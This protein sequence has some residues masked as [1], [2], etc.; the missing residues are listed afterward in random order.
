MHDGNLHDIAKIAIFALDNN[1][2]FT[3]N[4]LR[5]FPHCPV[6]GFT[7]K[8]ESLLRTIIQVE[9]ELVNNFGKDFVLGQKRRTFINQTTN[10]DHFICG[11]GHSIIDIDWN[12][13]VYPCHLL[14]K[15]CF[16][17]GNLIEDEIEAIVFRMGELNIR[18]QT[19]EIKKCK[20]CHFMSL[21]GGGCRAAAYYTYGTFEREDPLCSILYENELHHL[22]RM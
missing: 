3:P 6:D 9:D 7:L 18:K 17:L 8:D 2:G 12:G 21:C 14:R 22:E 13:D 15:N 5:K 4:N 10:R 16:I 11:V 1:G 19:F 20:H